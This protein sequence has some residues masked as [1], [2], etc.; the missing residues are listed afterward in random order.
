M[1]WISPTPGPYSI[2]ELMQAV[3]YSFS[4]L[5]IIGVHEFGHYFAAKFHKVD[6]TLPYFIPFPPIAG[7]LNFGTMGAVI[8]TRS[9]VRDNKTMFDIGVAGPIAGFIAAII[10]LIY[11]YTHLPGVEYILKIHPDYFSPDYGKNAIGLQFGNTIIFNFFNSVFTN[12]DQFI[13]PMSEIY[14]YPYLTAGWLG[15]FITAM[16]MIPVGQLDGGHVIY[17]MYGTKKH[18]VIAS[19]SMIILLVLGMAG[20][21]DTF[22][23][24]GFQFGWTGWLLWALILKFVIKIKHPPVMIFEPLDTKRMILGYISLIILVIS[25]SPNP[26]LISF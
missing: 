19:V 25:F 10:V 22:V 17:S 1:E 8:K 11:G 9:A 24:L 3:P 14:H 16:N 21:L 23:D 13:P 15:L 5:F 6:T 18:E 12:P 20:I 26:F 4:V 2:S 7:F